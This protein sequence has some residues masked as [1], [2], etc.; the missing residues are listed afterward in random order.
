MAR[1]GR[2]NTI[3]AFQKLD[4]ISE[5]KWG[6][7]GSIANMVVKTEQSQHFN[8]YNFLQSINMGLEKIL[9]T[10]I[11]SD[12]FGKAPLSIGEAYFTCEWSKNSF[13]LLFRKICLNISLRVLQCMCCNAC[14]AWT[15]LHRKPLREYWNTEF[16]TNYKECAKTAS[17]SLC[18]TGIGIRQTAMDTT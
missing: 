17:T 16:H 8:F 4:R 3:P 12:L 6:L 2:G 13:L 9:E 7:K 5:Q 18:F 1:P 15:T 11:C 10:S 14:A